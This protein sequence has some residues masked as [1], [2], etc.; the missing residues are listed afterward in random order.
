MT[1]SMID[2]LVSWLHE[3]VGESGARG[4]ILGISGGIDSAVTAA[5]AARAFPEN[6]LGLLLPCHSNKNDIADAVSLVNQ[7]GMRYHIIYLDGIYDDFLKMMRVYPEQALSAVQERTVETNIKPRLRMTTLYYMAGLLNYLV[8]GTSNKSEIAVGY[9]TKWGDNAVDLQLLGDLYKSE[10]YALAR[11]LQIPAGIISKPPSAGLW[12]GQTDEGEMGFTY[13]ELE[14]YLRTGHGDDS[15]IER[16]QCMHAISAHK[17][18]TP[19]IPD[20]AAF[21][22]AD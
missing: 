14:T 5:L 10:V 20:L 19:P 12:E 22:N 17:R 18:R 6:S 4:L 8:L 3:R 21:R 15:V 11:E 9:A 2:Y 7:I 16:I 1:K 13:G